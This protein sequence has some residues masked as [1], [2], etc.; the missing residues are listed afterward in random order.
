MNN[1]WRSWL[2]TWCY[3]VI[4]FGFVLCGAGIE[5]Y[6]SFT[7]SLFR[8]FNL[9][10]A[11]VFN[12]VERFSIGLM[13]AVTVGWGL[14]MLYYIRMAHNNNEGNRVW[15]QLAFVMLVWYAIDGYISYRTGFKL[16][17]ASNTVLALGLL[18]PL[19]KNGKLKR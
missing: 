16:N 11:P 6:E 19:W 12:E 3:L 9:Q 10:T 8:L 18:F 4:L 17:I 14:T 13:G 15:R 5:G 7:D 2:D 1:F